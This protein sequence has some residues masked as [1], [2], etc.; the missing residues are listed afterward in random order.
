MRNHSLKENYENL[1][2]AIIIQAVTDYRLS[3]K[4]I[5][6]VKEKLTGKD[7]LSEHDAIIL[8]NQIESSEKT[9]NNVK[10][11]LHSEYFCMLSNIDGDYIYKKLNKL[12]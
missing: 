6:K 10:D 4:R 8:N 11:F 5:Y 2:N 12:V 9:M 1:A 7:K 3:K